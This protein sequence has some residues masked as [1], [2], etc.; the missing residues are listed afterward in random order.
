MTSLM[1]KVAIDE[2]GNTVGVDSQVVR[3]T[4]MSQGLMITV[5]IS[6]KFNNF[7]N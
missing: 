4:A 6:A 3:V 1:N 2:S 7:H 5:R